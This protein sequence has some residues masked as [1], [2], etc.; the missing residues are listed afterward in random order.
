MV[1]GGAILAGWGFVGPSGT[2][3]RSAPSGRILC[4]QSPLDPWPWTTDTSRRTVDLLEF[5]ILLERDAILPIE[6]PSFVAAQR[7]QSQCPDPEPALVLNLHGDAR[8]Y[9]LRILHWHEIVNDRVGGEPV[10]ITWCPLCHSAVVFDRSVQNI[11]WPEGEN[12]RAPKSGSVS[13]EAK[14]VLDFGTSGMLRHSDLVLWDRQS[15]SWWQQFTGEALVGHF[16][17]AR[18]A[19]FP[20]ELMSCRQFRTQHPQGRMLSAPYPKAYDYGRNPYVDYEGSFPFALEGEPDPRLPPTARVLGLCIEGHCRA[21]PW[22]LLEREGV[23]G[24]ELGGRRIRLE[25]QKGVSSALSSA[26]MVEGTDRG[27]VLV[28]DEAG[29]LLEHH[30]TFAFAWFRFFPQSDLFTGRK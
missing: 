16:A 11:E 6:Q 28:R 23:V 18:L 13:P 17:G 7:S 14:R 10:A 25:H 19:V 27:R 9:P 5:S 26:V 20:S 29:R 24:D 2:K 21:Y 12:P 1:F 3:V 8:A 22:S 15:E 4:A 30:A